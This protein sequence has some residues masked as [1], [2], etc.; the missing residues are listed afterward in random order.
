MSTGRVLM[1]NQSGAYVIKLT[2]DVRMTL[3]TTLD[4]CLTRMIEDP[5]FTSVLVDVTEAEGIDSTSLGLLAKISRLATPAMGHVPTLI[6][7]H[8]DITRI[9]ETM[10]F[11]DRVFAIVSQ[12]E[13]DRSL[14][15]SEQSVEPL[16]E[17]SAHERVLEAHKILMSLNE[18]NRQTFRELVECMECQ[19]S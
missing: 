7:N 19:Q 17:T 1:A 2:G 8:P 14:A 3:C 4:N 16:D 18:K 13:I 6:S 9:I 15:L 12:A 10:G 11:R 5:K